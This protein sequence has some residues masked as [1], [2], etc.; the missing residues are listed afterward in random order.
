MEVVAKAI[1]LWPRSCRYPL[2]EPDALLVVRLHAPAPLGSAPDVDGAH[3]VLCRGGLELA[4]LDDPGR[5]H[6]EKPAGARALGHDEPRVQRAQQAVDLADHVE[7][8]GVL[9]VGDQV[10]DRRPL[11]GN[12]PH[13]GAHR[14]NA[15]E[16][17]LVLQ[18]LDG[19]LD[20][21]PV[22]RHVFRDQ[23]LARQGFTDLVVAREDAAADV[24]RYFLVSKAGRISHL[25][26][27][28]VWSRYANQY[29]TIGA[30]SRRNQGASAERPPR[31][32]P[33]A[34]DP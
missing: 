31:M 13:D 2:M 8:E 4:R 26:C 14:R 25:V 9:E 11:G 23:A 15:L 34:G 27:I 32:L 16:Q 28:P 19:P 3:E 20:R 6:V 5:T 21:R 7:V 10:A 29:H 24:L 18:D 33:G 1:R 17:A 12:L 30:L 22:G